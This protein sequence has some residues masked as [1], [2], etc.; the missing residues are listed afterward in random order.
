M[1]LLMYTVNTFGRSAR[2]HVVYG[3]FSS[4][5][6]LCVPK[7]GSVL[8]SENGCVGRSGLITE[9]RD[10]GGLASGC[11]DPHLNPTHFASLV[12][13]TGS[14]T[15]S[16]HMT[17]LEGSHD[18]HMTSIYPGNMRSRTFMPTRNG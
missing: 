4:I 7:L 15:S 14:M 13:T 2:I 5:G 1:I 12:V 16:G 8:G 11:V 6:M 3:N 17:L 9:N 18:G 10:G